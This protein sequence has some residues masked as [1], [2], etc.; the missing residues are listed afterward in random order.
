MQT[1]FENDPKLTDKLFTKLPMD[2]KVGVLEGSSQRADTDPVEML[3]VELK[4]CM[5]AKRLCYITNVR[6]NRPDLPQSNTVLKA[7]LVDLCKR[8]NFKEVQITL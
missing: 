2:N 3:G 6:R 7:N 5:R 1:N 4:K 8:L